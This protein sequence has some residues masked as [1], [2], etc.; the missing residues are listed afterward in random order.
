MDI[1]PQW[2]N[3]QVGDCISFVGQSVV[4][5]NK[6]DHLFRAVD[7][8][9][10]QLVVRGAIPDM[11]TV[12]TFLDLQIL[13]V[14]PMIVGCVTTQTK[15]WPCPPC[16]VADIYRLTEMCCGMGAFSSMG[17]LAGFEVLMGIDENPKWQ[18]LFKNTH[19]SKAAFLVGDIGDTSTI[20]EMLKAG[21]MH[22]TMLAGIACQPH[23]TGGDM[24]GMKDFRSTTLHKALKVSW[25]AQSPI[26]VLECVPG[27]LTNT[28]FQSVLTEFCSTVGACLTQQIVRLGNMWCAQRDRWFA[29]I[30]AGILGTVHIPD[31]PIDQQYDCVA[32][33]MPTLRAWPQSDL[34]QI[35]LSLYELSKFHTYVKGGI[36]NCFLAMDKKL[37]TSLHSAGNQLYAC[38]CGCRKALS[39]DRLRDRGLYGVLI[40]KDKVIDH[41]NMK[42]QDCRYMHPCEMY[43][44]NG[45]KPCLECDPDL[46][47]T[48][49][50]IGQFVSP[51]QG[52]WVLSHV[53]NHVAVFLNQPAIDPCVVLRMYVETV[54]S[55]RD[56]KWGVGISDPISSSVVPKDDAKP[57]VEYHIP[58]CQGKLIR[59]VASECARVG[60]FLAAESAMQGFPCACSDWQPQCQTPLSPD[61]P[62]SQVQ[63]IAQDAAPKQDVPEVSQDSS[64][65][66]KPTISTTVPYVVHDDRATGTVSALTKLKNDDFLALV[67]PLV[68]NLI[69]IQSLK[70]QL[71]SQE[72]R[73][74]MLENQGSIWADDEI[75]YALQQV[76][77]QGP[78]EQVII[79][80]D[81]LML[82]TVVR[83]GNFQ[84]LRDLVNAL[85]EKATVI[86]AFVVDKHWHPMLW[87]FEQDGVYAYTCGLVHAFSLAH[88][89]VQREICQVRKVNF[90]AVHN[91]PLP[92]IVNDKCGAL[93]I[94][95]LR[96]L[97]FGNA[98]PSS[99]TELAQ[100]HELM[101]TDFLISCQDVTPRPW[102]WAKGQDETKSLLATLLQNHGVMPEDAM[103]R[104]QLIIDK[105]GMK[106]V[107]QSFRASNPWKELKWH[108]NQLTPAFQLIRPSELQSVLDQKIASGKPIGNRSQK[109]V[110]AKGKGKGKAP[111]IDPHKLRVETGIFVYGDNQA[112]PQIDL[113]HIGPAINGVVLCD[114]PMATP[115]L[116]GGKQLSAGGLAMVV[117]SSS[118]QLPVTALIA[119]KVRIPVVCAANAEPLLIDGYL[120]QLGAQPVRRN[121]NQDRFKLESV[122]SCVGKFSVYRDQIDIPWD[123]FV[124]HP[125]KHLFSKIPV[126]QACTDD[127]CGGCCERWHRAQAC[128][129]IDPILEIWNKQ[130]MTYGYASSSPDRAE[131]YSVCIRLPASVQMQVQTYSGSAGIYVE[132][133][134]IDGRQPSS[135]FQVV[136]LPKMEH[137]DLNVLRQ[138]HPSVCGLARM[139]M[140][141]G[142]RCRTEHAA[143]LFT[144]VKPSSSYLPQGKKS[145]FLVGPVPYG[146]LRASLAEALSSV[147]WKVRPLQTATT[148]RNAD[149]IMWRVQAVEDPPCNIIQLQHG[150]VLVTKLED[151]HVSTMA[152]VQ[153]VG[154]D[155]TKQL[156]AA[157]PSSSDPLQQHDPWAAYSKQSVV[158]V[159]LSI[160]DE[161][162]ANLEKKV[163]EAVMAKIPKES[164]EI[165]D[166]GMEKRFQDMEQKVMTLQEGQQQL[167]HRLQEQG[168]TQGNQIQQLYAQS[169][170]LEASVHEQSVAL[171]HFQ[172]QFQAQLEQQQGQ[173]DSLFQQQM[174][175]IEEILKKPRHE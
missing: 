47:L 141:L 152:S 85:P 24:G 46:R 127:M 161:P 90:T 54:I 56:T 136:W 138:L 52:L 93:A 144:S 18:T 48:M 109:V 37:P 19:S 50:A 61:L 70:Q 121:I 142:L 98:L 167:H 163:L 108:A 139:G 116:K 99:L 12:Y 143:S 165:D 49:A 159:P 126:L 134:A 111:E 20:N 75:S 80:W 59:F 107:A 58:D 175:R 38:R 55:I 158:S 53:A 28:E 162:M 60:D 39:L 89:T 30:S 128:A 104:V 120:Y 169:T 148:S 166:D 130:W 131:I 92:Y 103:Q 153:V 36:Q 140:K 87:R 106:V 76:V 22:S 117:L 31:L 43:L 160:P 62:L 170:R 135:Q 164:M 174:S 7:A 74:T 154:S 118:D 6:G 150:E 72:A 51:I 147:G 9:R 13:Q 157:N 41:N 97:V 21:A 68:D 29:C 84:I 65:A 149:G 123:Q 145:T 4:L 63:F 5:D 86:T 112:V 110:K 155:R 124:L 91:R 10:C 133:R 33:V 172:T 42:M 15:L 173:L 83:V 17:P 79:Q 114:V 82:S 156:C 146:T 66:L 137:Q 45:G 40:P 113:Q 94:A 100:I 78:S 23:S 3:L 151:P 122:D 95:F 11:A 44:L 64:Q 2:A 14:V 125:L 88:Q 34:D 57:T 96:H 25:L 26:L 69:G 171:G 101:R 102:V 168:A 115:Y 8:S 32:K 16:Y 129:V 27:V 73:L 105:L 119:E 81:P 67:P 77:N 1:F 35:D 71:I 132:P